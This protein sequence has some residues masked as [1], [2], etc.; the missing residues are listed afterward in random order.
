MEKISSTRDVLYYTIYSLDF[1]ERTLSLPL[2][3]HG[4]EE[5]R[6]PIA[7]NEIT[8]ESI[9]ECPFQI[10]TSTNGKI[11]NHQVIRD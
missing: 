5:D 3:A 2:P 11:K 6:D 9:G 1:A 10:K 7:A 8:T 4:K